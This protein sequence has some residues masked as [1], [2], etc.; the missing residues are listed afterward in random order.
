MDTKPRSHAVEAILGRPRPRL[1]PEAEAR[2]AFDEAR[3]PRSRGRESLML[4]VRRADG[5]RH[6][7]SY[8]Y[9]MR[10][11]FEPGDRLRLR[12]GEAV[13]RV[14]GR[15][16]GDLYRR[17]LEHRVEGIQEGTEAEGGLK[18][19]QAPHIDRVE[20]ITREEADHDSED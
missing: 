7:L 10:V 13:V 6:A 11:D 5:Q 9:L 18:P 12:F 4:D 15:R 19:D 17:L 2:E 20:V 14:E 3:A 16:L 1:E 8:A